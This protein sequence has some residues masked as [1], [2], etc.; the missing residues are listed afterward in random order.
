MSKCET[1]ANFVYQALVSIKL[2][3]GKIFKG[4]PMEREGKIAFYPRCGCIYTRREW[5]RVTPN[6]RKPRN[7]PC[8]YKKK[9][10]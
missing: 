3:D 5:Y 6:I 2:F 4:T 9:E 1:C 10:G 7:M 8:D